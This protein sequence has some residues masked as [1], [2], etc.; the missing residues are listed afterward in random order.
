MLTRITYVT[1]AALLVAAKLGVA[2]IITVDENGNGFIDN[3]PISGHLGTDPGPGGLTN[4][5]I[6]NLPF[7]GAQGDIFLTD[8]DFGGLRLDV[9]RF[10]GNGTLI[11]YS[12]N[13]DGFDA[14]G[15]TPGPPLLDYANLVQLPEVGPE[16]NNGSFWIPAAGQPGFDPSGITY[17]F[18]SDGSASPVPEPRYLILVGGCLALFGLGRCKAIRPARFL[19]SD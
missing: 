8:A 17:H 15:D 9:I 1:A 6:Y 16:G 5:L 11:F 18:I 13:V 12:D 10:N 19:R 14:I 4:V 2:S 7:A 3:T